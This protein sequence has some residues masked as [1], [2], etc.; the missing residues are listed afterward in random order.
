M[1]EFKFEPPLK[2]VGRPNVTVQ[3]LDDAAD[4]VRHYTGARRPMSRDSVLRRLEGA[5]N[6][7]QQR[8]AADAFRWWAEFEG[9]LIK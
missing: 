3:S 9:L 7:E 4:Y 1:A 8:E 6:A 5:T 2:L